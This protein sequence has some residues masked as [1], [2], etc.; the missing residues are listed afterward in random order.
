MLLI[1]STTQLNL[2]KFDQH[3][4]YNATFMG[5][6]KYSLSPMYK[7]ELSEIDTSINLLFIFHFSD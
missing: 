6:R 4:S 7:M 1:F 2:E 5:R 3:E